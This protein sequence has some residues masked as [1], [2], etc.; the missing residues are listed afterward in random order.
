MISSITS[1]GTYGA[2]RPGSASPAVISAGELA[3]A[4]Q[5][6]DAAEAR[7]RDLRKEATQAQREAETQR[8]ASDALEAQKRSRE[9]SDFA[10]Q[11]GTYRYEQMPKTGRLLNTRA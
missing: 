1:T 9:Q 8:G 4:R 11:L 6:A 3:R 7:A 5:I 2:V 10:P